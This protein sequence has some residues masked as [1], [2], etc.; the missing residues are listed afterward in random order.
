MSFADSLCVLPRPILLPASLAGAPRA[1]IYTS[2]W[3][4]DG[5]LWFGAEVFATANANSV[6]SAFTF[7]LWREDCVEL[8][9]ANPS[10]GRYVEF[11]L[12]PTGAWWSCGF[13][14]VRVQDGVD[15]IRLTPRCYATE[16]NWTAIGGIRLSDLSA[17]LGEGD[18]AANVTVIVG[19]CDDDNPDPANL[20]SVVTLTGDTPDFHRPVDFVPLDQLLRRDS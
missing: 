10:N 1:P 14:T 4:E 11:N 19:G 8:F 13:L 2:V 16:S 7:G 17:R 6:A 3:V 20:H 15:P 9:V 12:A 5:H 18:Y